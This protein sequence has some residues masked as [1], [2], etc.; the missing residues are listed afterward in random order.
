MMR[1]DHLLESIRCE[2]GHFP[3]L[4]YHQQRVQRAFGRLWPDKPVPELEQHL[5][6]FDVPASGLYKCRI[7]YGTKL[8]KPVYHP[9]AIHLPAT[10][11]CVICDDID[12]TL[13]WSDRQKLNALYN[14][15]AGC[16]DVLIV[17]NG[18]ITD[19]SYCNIAF[20]RDGLWYTPAKPLLEGVRRASLLDEGMINPLDILMTDLAIFT[21]FKVFNAMIGWDDCPPLPVSAISLP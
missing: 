10:L 21:H 5:Q 9:Y 15:K 4:R 3:L 11:K 18:L 7:V 13:K 1:D 8:R 19:T 6:C 2:D 17:K 20:L 16:D 12:Y 14:Q